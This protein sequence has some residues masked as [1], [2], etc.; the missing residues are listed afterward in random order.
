ME[1]AAIGH[2]GAM[3][4]L[5]VVVTC[6]C[7]P[8]GAALAHER[9]PAPPPPDPDAR[10]PQIR[11]MYG[12]NQPPARWTTRELQCVV[13]VQFHRVG[14]AAN[15]SR[16]VAC[17]SVWNPRVVSRTDDHGLFQINR[18]WNGEGWRRGANIYDPVWNTRIA[19]WFWQTRGWGDWTC[20]RIMGV[21]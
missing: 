21:S 4:T 12:C 2:V 8:A 5:L 14:Q 13:W 20:S 15:A 16:I 18:R 11:R 17:E 9:G 7:V 6:F 3:R 1:A 19:F 10:T